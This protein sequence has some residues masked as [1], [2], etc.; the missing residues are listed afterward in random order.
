MLDDED[1]DNMEIW[2]RIH[3]KKIFFEMQRIFTLKDRA[4]LV[5]EHELRREG[6][7][8]N[9]LFNASALTLQRCYRGSAARNAVWFKKEVNRVNIEAKKM[10]EATIS[11]SGW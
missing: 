3:R 7:R 1:F 10:R 9:K 2:N 5:Q 8:K 11:T 6:I 4:S